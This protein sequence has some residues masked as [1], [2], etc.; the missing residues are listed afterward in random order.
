MKDEFLASMSHELRTPLNSILGLSEALKEQ[1][2]GTLNQKQ[3]DSLNNIHRSGRHL[4]DLINDILDLAKIESGKTEFNFSLV[5]VVSL[6]LD[7]LNFI[8]YLAEKKKILPSLSSTKFPLV[9]NSVK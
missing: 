7:S 1:V 8:R 6:S 9:T 5:D 3:L 4:L 2:F